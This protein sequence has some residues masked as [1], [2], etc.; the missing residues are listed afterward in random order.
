MG[1]WIFMSVMA[2]LIP[3][4]MICFGR[5]FLSGRPRRINGAFGYRSR[6]SMLNQAAWDFAHRYCGRLW[7]R[8][9]LIMLP[10]SAAAMLPALG[11][12]ADTVGYVGGAVALIQCA[13]MACSILSVERAL[14]RAFDADGN[15]TDSM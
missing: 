14:K 2:L 8:M 5:L 10:I 1:F 15:R 13:V 6:L 3:A 4:A 12:D 7:L 9:G 11:R